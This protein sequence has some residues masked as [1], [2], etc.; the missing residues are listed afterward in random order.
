M[1]KDP[2]VFLHHIVESIQFIEQYTSGMIF[3]EFER[4]VEKQDSV[5]RRFEVIGEAVR[6]LPDDFRHK[7]SSKDINW[8]TIIGMRDEIIHH[9]FG[10]DLKVVWDTIEH[11]LPLLKR[12]VQ[13]M[14]SNE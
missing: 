3:T 4:N 2:S 9:Y 8:K 11:D 10:I 6:N 1:K 12:A 7:Y 5:M 13:R 14:L